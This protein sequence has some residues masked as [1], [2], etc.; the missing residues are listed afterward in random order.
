M[1]I[2]CSVECAFAFGEKYFQVCEHAIDKQGSVF[3]HSHHKTN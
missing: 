3:E 2:R 1:M